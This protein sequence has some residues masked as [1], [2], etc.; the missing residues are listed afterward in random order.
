MDVTMNSQE[1]K[2]SG[3]ITNSDINSYFNVDNEEKRISMKR[4]LTHKI[5]QMSL[6]L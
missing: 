6:K 2:E 4:K 1:Q 3:H 5:M